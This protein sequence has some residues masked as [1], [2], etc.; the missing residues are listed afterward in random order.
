MCPEGG[1]PEGDFLILG[2]TGGVLV[3]EV[4][5]ANFGGFP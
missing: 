2:P 4:K 1:D 5:V 3:L